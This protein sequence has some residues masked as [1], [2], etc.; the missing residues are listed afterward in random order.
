MRGSGEG[1]GTPLE[2]FADGILALE[3]E[4]RELIRAAA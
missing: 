1:K 3:P 4:I 2:L